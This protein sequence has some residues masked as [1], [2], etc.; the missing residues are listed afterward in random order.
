VSGVI[1]EFPTLLLPV[2][3]MA[4]VVLVAR[5]RKRR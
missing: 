2:I 4:A 1:P 5:L 3:G